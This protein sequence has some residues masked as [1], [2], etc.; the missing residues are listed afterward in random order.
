MTSLVR[1]QCTT[2]RGAAD[3]SAAEM[4]PLNL[5]RLAPAEGMQVVD[6]FGLSRLLPVLLDETSLGSFS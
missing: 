3:C 4:D 1:L 2:A 6:L 5:I